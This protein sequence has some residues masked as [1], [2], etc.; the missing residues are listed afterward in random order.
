MRD[1]KSNKGDKGIFAMGAV[2]G[3]E[4]TPCVTLLRTPI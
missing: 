2:Q 4:P 1:R 3:L